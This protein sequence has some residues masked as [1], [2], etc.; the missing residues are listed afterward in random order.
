MR[1]NGNIS[2]TSYMLTSAPEKRKKLYNQC[3]QSNS[4]DAVNKFSYLGNMIHDEGHINTTI[5]RIQIKNRSYYVNSR[6]V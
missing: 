5:D 1:L 6:C 2:K 4:F 3:I